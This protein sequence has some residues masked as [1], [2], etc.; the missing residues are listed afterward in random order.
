MVAKREK[1]VKFM[2]DLACDQETKQ[3]L[4]PEDDYSA[5]HTAGQTITTFQPLS[6]EE[7]RNKM[8]NEWNSP[9]SDEQS[10]DTSS[11]DDTGKESSDHAAS[12]DEGSRNNKNYEERGV[13]VPSREQCTLAGGGTDIVAVAGSSKLGKGNAEEDNVADDSWGFRSVKPSVSL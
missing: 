9:D 1:L 6:M 8:L 4:L 12:F 7:T 5:S 13:Q 2:Y 11:G 10:T 3:L